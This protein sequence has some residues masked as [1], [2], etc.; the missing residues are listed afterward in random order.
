MNTQ[1]IRPPAFQ[2]PSGGLSLVTKQENLVDTVWTLV[3]LD[4]K[5]NLFKD[6][7]EDTA[8]HLIIIGVAGFYSISAC[9]YFSN[10][11]AN[12]SYAAYIN[13]TGGLGILAQTKLHSSLTDSLMIPVVRASVFLSAG[14][15][16]TLWAQS[17]SGD[18]TVDVMNGIHTNLI[19]QRVR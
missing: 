12:K 6:E 10:P 3:L 15:N 17:N 8:N 16:I 7:I 18:N 9:V 4:N 19:V 1:I 11:V 14:E 13:T 5:L 2:R